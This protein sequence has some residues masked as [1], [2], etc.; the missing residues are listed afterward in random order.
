M[1]SKFE[2]RQHSKKRHRMEIEND[3]KKNSLF[4]YAGPSMEHRF[5]EPTVNE[6]L[7]LFAIIRTFRKSS[8]QKLMYQVHS[9]ILLSHCWS[10]ETGAFKAQLGA[11]QSIY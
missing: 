7:E 6:L 9:S 8:Y 1:G 11:I 2:R 3:R 4:P 10:L 5:E